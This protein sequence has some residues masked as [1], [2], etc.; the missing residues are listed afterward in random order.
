M[1]R[2]NAPGE[3]KTH[4][5]PLVYQDTV[6]VRTIFR[7]LYQTRIKQFIQIHQLRTTVLTSNVWVSQIW[8]FEFQSS[9]L[10]QE[11]NTEFLPDGEE[12]VWNYYKSYILK[13]NYNIM[14]WEQ[15]KL[16]YY[17]QPKIPEKEEYLVYR[18]EYHVL[19]NQLAYNLLSNRKNKEINQREDNSNSR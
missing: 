2:T 11:L 5:R 10:T 1:N 17:N 19:W 7:S 15:I 16:R 3:E 4:M 13:S 8:A 9:W 12:L 6:G 18:C 14:S